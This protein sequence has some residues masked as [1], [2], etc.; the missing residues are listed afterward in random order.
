M[1]N[2]ALPALPWRI[3][4]IE[5]PVPA[6]LE[7][8]THTGVLWQAA[9]GRF[10]LDVPDVARYLA[11]DGARLTVD[12]APGASSYDIARFARMTPLAALCY[13][14]GIP[15]LHA[16]AASRADDCVIIAGDS[17]SGKS[18]LLAELVS[19]GWEILAEDLA[20]VDL[21]E[22]GR[23]VVLPTETEIRLWPDAVEH[24]GASTDA[25][26]ERRHV[27]DARPASGAQP[28][29]AIWRLG[30]HSFDTIEV[31]DVTGAER[32]QMVASCTYNTQI[33]SALLDRS[34]FMRVSSKVA[35]TLAI[36]RIRR[37]RI[38]W[39]VPEL[40]DLIEANAARQDAT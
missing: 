7:E 26:R 38:R 39:T 20:P 8:P 18:A 17:A 31:E 5:A 9:R 10:L 3:E 32:F 30:S 2:L 15:A 34:A 19:R 12:P 36:W 35:A 6:E 21:D 4:V 27:T 22:D 14:R 13:Q 16:A 1:Q 25:A 24:L 29:R 37:P 23:A 11:T 28:L 40:A 33:A